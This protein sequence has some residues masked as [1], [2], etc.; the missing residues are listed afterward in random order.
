MFSDMEPMLDA[1]I[2]GTYDDKANFGHSFKLALDAFGKGELNKDELVQVLAKSLTW[3]DQSPFW[4]GTPLEAYWH[5]AKV[6]SALFQVYKNSSAIVDVFYDLLQGIITETMNMGEKALSGDFGDLNLV[7]FE[8]EIAQHQ[9]KIQAAL[10]AQEENTSLAVKIGFM[11]RDAWWL[12]KHG[13]AAL[14]GYIAKET[15]IKAGSGGSKSSTA[16][17]RKRL[18]ALLHA[19]AVMVRDNQILADDPMEENAFR[20]LKLARKAHPDLFGKVSSKKTAVEYW[21]YIKSDPLLWREYQ[22]I[23]FYGNRLQG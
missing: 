20:A 18:E 5:A 14:R 9:E 6:Q 1:F 15:A 23:L 19:H 4:G 2:V 21:G 17:R 12:E 13:D 22:N 3:L 11:Y 7:D 16:A 10:R 8:H